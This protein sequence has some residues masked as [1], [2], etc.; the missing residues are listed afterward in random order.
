MNTTQRIALYQ[1]R[2][3]LR[4]RWIVLHFLAYLAV[5]EGMLLTGGASVKAVVGLV[6]V[7]LLL[8]PLVSLVFGVMRLYDARDFV[9]TLLTQP[10][11]RSAL[12]GGLYLGLA[13]PLAV[14]FAAGILLPFLVH[15]ALGGETGVRVAALVG[16]GVAL[17]LVFT[18]VAFLV[19][20]RQQ[21]RVRGIGLA[22]VT[23]IGFA[24]AFDAV[25]LLVVTAFAQY[26][27]ERPML[28][29]VFLNPVDLARVLLLMLLDA[30]ALMG[31]TGA[32]F[33]RFF[34]S[35]AG[36]AVS[37]TALGLWALAPWVAARNAFVSRDF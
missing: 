37:V 33:S 17:T 18:A 2:D 10:V 20:V 28:V 11:R 7:V 21:D 19:A 6:N 29:V 13:V 35:A 3:A 31:Y 8:V 30:A 22:L 15:G 26:P 14:T 4:S 36:L 1:A 23:W 16:C 32:V 24:L 25:V 12:F 34:G 9:L 27:L 5:A